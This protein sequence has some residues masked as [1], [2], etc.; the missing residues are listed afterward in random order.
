MT[1]TFAPKNIAIDGI[2]QEYLWHWQGQE[3]QVV[4][5]TLGQGTPVL[6]LPAFSTVSTRLEMAGL[7]KLL[8]SK[9]QIIVLD[10]PGFGDSSRP[11]LDYKPE[12]YQQFLQDFVTNIFNNPVAVVAAGH[13]AGYA[14]QLAQKQPPVWSKIVLAV[15]TWRGPLPTMAGQRLGLFDTLREIVRSPIFGQALYKLNTVPSFLRWMYRRHVFVDENHL[16]PDFIRQKWEITQQTG[17]RFAPAA[18]VTGTLDPVSDRSEFVALFKDLSVPVMVVIGEQ[19]PP[20]S[21]A[22]MA[23]LSLLPGMESSLLP[24]TL[25]LHE[26]YADRLAEIILPFLAK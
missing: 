26:E 12:L 11:R 8:A 6:L 20:K 19:S 5:E 15:P 16:T 2:R 23:A 4:Y 17:A 22:E 25:G 13:A 7:A 24:G 14:M 1:A 10:W 3:L 9:Y 18:F 21:K